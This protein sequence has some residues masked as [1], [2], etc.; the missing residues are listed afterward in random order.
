MSTRKRLSIKRASKWAAALE[1][2]DRQGV[3]SK[4]LSGFMHLSGG[5]EGAARARAKSKREMTV[6]DVCHARRPNAV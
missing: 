6:R 3:H 2:A 4:R 1:Y 5:I